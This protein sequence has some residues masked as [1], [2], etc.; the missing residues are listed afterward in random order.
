MTVDFTTDELRKL[1]PYYAVIRKASPNL[2]PFE[3][4]LAAQV[5]QGLEEDPNNCKDYK[6][7]AIAINEARGN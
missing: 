5:L 3:T 7:V 2:P 6:S 4:R 1:A